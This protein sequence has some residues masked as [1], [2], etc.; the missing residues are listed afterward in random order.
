MKIRQV[1]NDYS[2]TED[3]WF[4]FS[5]SSG[6]IHPIIEGSIAFTPCFV[7]AS[8]ALSLDYHL[9]ALCGVIRLPVPLRSRSIPDNS[10]NTP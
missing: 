2:S 8:M 3:R 1:F 9:I 6:R 5:T 4:Y 10:L 7:G